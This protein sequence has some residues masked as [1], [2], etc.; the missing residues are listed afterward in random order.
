VVLT[1]HLFTRLGVT[2][3]KS[4][5]I[6]MTYALATTEKIIRRHRSETLRTKQN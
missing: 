6:E 2:G 1:A 3:D 5:A 4:K